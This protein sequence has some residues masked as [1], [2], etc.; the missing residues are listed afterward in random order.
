MFIVRPIQI[1]EEQKMICD[2]L[3][4]EYFE[5]S[6]AFYSADLKSDNTTI[7]SYIGICQFYFSGEAEIVSF[8]ACDGRENDEAVIVML[9]AAMS[10]MHRCGVKIV[11]FK[12]G[13]ATD[14]WL[15]KSGFI[16]KDGS[17]SMD[18][19]RFYASTCN[20]GE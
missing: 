2:V 17:Y 11:R 3:E 9:R 15:K 4:C 8:F 1:K 16:F 12:K 13:A 10:F 5:N 19:E 20:H 18:L 14:F 6:L 7:D